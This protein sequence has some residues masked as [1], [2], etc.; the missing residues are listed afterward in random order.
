MNHVKIRRHLE[1]V[2]REVEGVLQKYIVA[3]GCPCCYSP[4]IYWAGKE[5][6]PGWQDNIQNRLVK[7]ALQLDCFEKT[8]QDVNRYGY[9][10]S[11]IC[12]RCN[13]VW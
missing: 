11:Y 6:G 4:F 2:K 10:G 7:S 13:S 5:Q 9:Q 1:L 3:S 8:E 12:S